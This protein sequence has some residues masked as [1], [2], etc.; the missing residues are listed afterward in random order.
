MEQGKKFPMTWKLL[1]FVAACCVTAAGVIGTLAFAF[2]TIQPFGLLDQIYLLIFGFFMG[3][4]VV[5]LG[6]ASTFFGIQK[7][8]KLDK[9]RKAA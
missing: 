6:G 8:L 7:S 1:F 2:T 3:G 9:V 4:Y 5:G